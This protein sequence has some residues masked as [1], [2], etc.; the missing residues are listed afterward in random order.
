[1]SAKESVKQNNNKNSER[2]VHE[3]AEEDFEVPGSRL[4]VVTL[5]VSGGV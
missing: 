1:M 3:E 5:G 4:T 2:S